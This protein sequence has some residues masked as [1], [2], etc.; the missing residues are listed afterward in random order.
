MSVRGVPLARLFAVILCQAVSSLS[1]LTHACFMNWVWHCTAAYS[2]RNTML[3]WPLGA[4]AQL[5]SCHLRQ[6]ICP[7]CRFSSSIS[8]LCNVCMQP[9]THAHYAVHRPQTS[10]TLLIAWLGQLGSTFFPP[11]DRP[12]ASLLGGHTKTRQLY[13]LH[14][15]GGPK[16]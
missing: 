13:L 16:K 1:W 10:L 8:C 14:I 4:T 15:Q 5:L 7:F 6:M 9:A 12:V 3:G 2:G 11:S